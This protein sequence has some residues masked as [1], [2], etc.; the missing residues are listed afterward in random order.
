MQSVNSQLFTGPISPTYAYN[1]CIGIISGQQTGE[2]LE[3]NKSPYVIF[4]FDI[5]AKSRDERITRGDKILGKLLEILPEDVLRVVRTCSGGL[6]IYS[7]DDNTIFPDKEGKKNRFIKIFS[8]KHVDI[9]VF[10]PNDPKLQS[11]VMLP[12]SEAMKDKKIYSYSLVHSASDDFL[13]K[14]SKLK[15]ALSRMGYIFDFTTVTKE[16]PKQSVEPKAKPEESKPVES[17]P[18]LNFSSFRKPKPT[19]EEKEVKVE[20]TNDGLDWARYSTKERMTEEC[21]I[22]IVNGFIVS[23]VDGESEGPCIH[24]DTPDT[25]TLYREITLMPLFKGFNALVKVGISKNDIYDA[26]EE[27]RSEGNLTPN[28]REHWEELYE[29]YKNDMNQ[30]YGVLK[31]FLKNHNRE[32]YNKKVIPLLP[33]PIPEISF[34]DT[35]TY[36]DMFYENYTYKSR[37]EGGEE[38]VKINNRKCIFDLRRILVFV[39]KPGGNVWYLKDDDSILGGFYIKAITNKKVLIS[40]LKQIFI[41]KDGKKHIT[42]ATIFENLDNDSLKP[43]IR[44]AAKFYSS[45]P[46]DFSMWRGWAINPLESGERVN[47]DIINTWLNH[48]K[49]ICCTLETPTGGYD[50]G[51]HNKELFTFLKYHMASLFQIPDLVSGIVP[52]ITGTPGAGKNAI[53]DIL[54]VMMGIYADPNLTDMNMITG[55][56]NSALV[57]KHLIILNELGQTEDEAQKNWDIM[58]ALVTQKA[59]GINEKNVAYRTVQNVVNFIIVSNHFNPVRLEEGDR[60][61]LM[62]KVCDM[63][64]GNTDYFNNL[65]ASVSHPDF[66]RHLLTYFLRKNLKKLDKNGNPKFNPRVLP[67]TAYK[68]SLTQPKSIEQFI[69][70]NVDQFYEGY[71]NSLVYRHFKTY[72]KDF[73][74]KDL[75][76]ASFRKLLND[77]CYRHTN[78]E[79]GELYWMIK[80]ANKKRFPRSDIV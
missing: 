39:P 20:E 21:F 54:C 36:H 75:N 33:A 19:V 13:V 1:K 57:N 52:V 59:I 34:E 5:K 45:N 64:A 69:I 62:I 77:H 7:M 44:R 16:N 51:N 61:Y 30:H 74:F 70:D 8:N 68:E 17:K 10:F 41:K 22:S 42:M 65:W 29:R 6:H 60:R 14:T 35:F 71:S 49:N 31:T 9:D 73:G 26:L 28:A 15:V 50:F 11:L 55:N 58:K 66:Y 38:V 76:Y 67:K 27:I 4:D 80:D 72:A 37:D 79:D 56:F 78:K 53:T 18:K 25:E 48:V 46:N 24:K 63:Y 3:A 40:D 32:Y 47:K 23:G 43:F 2:A 12:G